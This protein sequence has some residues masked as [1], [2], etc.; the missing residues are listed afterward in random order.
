MVLQRAPSPASIWGWAN[1]GSGNVTVVVQS[2][3]A[4]TIKASSSA[5][6]SLQGKWRVSL[7][8][9][10]AT[11]DPVTI[12]ATL[13]TGAFVELSDVLFGDVWVCSGQSNSAFDMM[14]AL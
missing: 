8:P 6:V 13:T 14:Q 5:P 12:K 4:G 10:P 9:Q 11:S 3:A 7:P 1:A 2:G